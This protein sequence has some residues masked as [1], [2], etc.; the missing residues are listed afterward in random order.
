MK[1]LFTSFAVLALASLAAAH[2]R[3]VSA[4][5][6]HTT[7][8]AAI[9][10]SRDD[11]VIL[12]KSGTYP[13]FA[14][15]GKSLVIAEDVGHTVRI[16]GPIRIGGIDGTRTVTLM[17]LENVAGTTATITTAYGLR[18]TNSSGLV[19]VQDCTLRAPVIATTDVQVLTQ[20]RPALLVENSLSVVLSH[21]T[22]AGGPSVAGQSPN[23]PTAGLPYIS[24]VPSEG[25]YLA[26]SGVSFFESTV[27]GGPAVNGYIDG[28]DGGHA[29]W[30][31]GSAL[32]L[33]RTSVIGGDG[34]NGN[35][36]GYGCDV[37]AAAGDGGHGVFAPSGTAC[38]T[39]ATTPSGGL[40]GRFVVG[41]FGAVA[42][43][44]DGVPGDPGCTSI[45][46]NNGTSVVL[47]GGS[48]RVTQPAT[49]ER[50]FASTIVRERATGQ[51]TFN[52]DVGANVARW[53]SRVGIASYDPVS[54]SIQVTS[55][56]PSYR[57]TPV[58]VAASAPLLDPIPVPKPLPDGPHRLVFYQGAHTTA[59]G[60]RLGTPRALLMLDAS[61]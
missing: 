42:N 1:Q 6:P 12:V 44:C 48:T 15:R 60:L 59:A 5:G 11:D 41:W 40:R 24:G 3:V 58:G 8:Q 54:Q 18:V 10:V 4:S 52:A 49:T 57:T 53:S 47:A 28:S 32:F 19:F 46:G 27:T 22:V 37:G 17:G 30:S 16:N 43:N 29:I 31:V 36:L 61:Y 39:R 56:G 55:F 26:N 51:L 38:I 35:C 33:C 20:P 25:A 21:C 50:L 23:Y 13:S 7:I 14:V 45:L 9:D 2:V 34:G